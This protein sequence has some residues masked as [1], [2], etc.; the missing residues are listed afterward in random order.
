[1]VKLRSEILRKEKIVVKR[2]ILKLWSIID[3]IYFSCTRLQCLEQITGHSNI[4]R[5]RLT[6]YKGR[7]VQLSDGTLIRKNDTLVKIHLHNVRILREMQ[8]FDEFKKSVFLYKKVQESLPDLAFYISHHKNRN[9]IK[10]IIGIS[11]IDKGYKRFGFE[12]FPCSSLSYIW[13]K[14]LALYP[15]HF[16]SRTSRTSKKKRFPIPQYLFMSKNTL[17]K[18]YGLFVNN[19][20]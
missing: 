3:P 18:K 9:Q 15:I 12:S 8:S 13:F 5:V 20:A 10:G 4:F 11:F 1:M 16:L 19:V 7:E 6:R 14:R 17:C 2:R